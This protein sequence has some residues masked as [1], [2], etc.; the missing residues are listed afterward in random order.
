MPVVARESPRGVAPQRHRGTPF[1]WHGGN[2][3]DG[4]NR[5][6]RHIE[7]PDDLGRPRSVTV[8]DAE[9]E[10]VQAGRERRREVGAAAQL[11]VAVRVPAVAGEGSLGIAAGPR[12]QGRLIGER[13]LG[14]RVDPRRRERV[15]PHRGARLRRPAAIVVLHREVECVDPERELRHQRGCVPH[16]AVV[17]RTPA[18]RH[19][20]AVAAAA[21]AVAHH[22]GA[23]VHHLRPRCDG[24]GGQTV[25]QHYLHRV[26][27]RH[28]Q[29]AS[30]QRQH[31]GVA[32]RVVLVDQQRRRRVAEAHRHHPRVVAPH[33][34]QP[35]RDDYSQCV[36]GCG[37]EA[38]GGGVG[39][40]AYIEC[41]QAVAVGHV[42]VAVSH[43]HL[44][45]VAGSVVA[46]RQFRGRGSAY[47]DDAEP[48]EVRHVGVV[49]R[50]RHAPGVAGE[51]DVAHLCRRS[52]VAHIHHHQPP[53]AVGHIGVTVGHRHAVGVERG[54]IGH[55]HRRGG[56][57]DI[58]H[59]QPP[60]GRGH[61]GMVARQRHPVGVAR[62]GQ[63]AHH[64]RVRRVAQVEQPQP[65]KIAGHRH[66]IPSHREAPRSRQIHGRDTSQFHRRRLHR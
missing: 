5:W 47:V 9:A 62:Q 17:V 52:G 31:A 13:P 18:M 44:V 28:D 12:Q 25:H 63:L 16:L 34:H 57:R 51:R 10:P 42:G 38:H 22:G 36:I 35:P 15:D 66:Q 59:P 6:S 37:E 61:V 23:L 41:A 60:A 7:L 49:A 39:R 32:R 40:V 21:R 43:R 50:Q 24:G 56:L 65:V 64:L 48:L 33:Q 55:F 1:H 8:L 30:D 4:G 14:G 46:A 2:G 3:S 58:H 29:V 54:E 45:G 27:V 53:A 11:A 26:V 20:L 19:H